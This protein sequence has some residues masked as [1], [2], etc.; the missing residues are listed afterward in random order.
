M[1][2]PQ[3]PHHDLVDRAADERPGNQHRVSLANSHR[4]GDRLVV[5]A[6]RPARL[7]H[8]DPIGGLQIERS[9]RPR[10]A[11]LPLRRCILDA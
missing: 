6:R 5:D 2:A 3:C 1:F 10:S 7:E 4:A 11:E 9:R 8:D